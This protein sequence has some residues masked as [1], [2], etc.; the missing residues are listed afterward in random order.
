MTDLISPLIIASFIIEHKVKVFEPGSGPYCSQ[1]LNTV[2]SKYCGPF[3]NP[4]TTMTAIN[5]PI[6][7][8]HVE[9]IL[10]LMQKL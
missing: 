1:A 7:G 8:K 4:S 10:I 6:C 9:N 3:L 2:N 5:V